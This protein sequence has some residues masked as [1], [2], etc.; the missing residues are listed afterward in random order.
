MKEPFLYYKIIYDGKVFLLKT[1]NNGLKFNKNINSILFFENGN[2]IKDDSKNRVL[3][4]KYMAGWI[5][6][7][8]YLSSEEV[9][10]LIE[11]NQFS[12]EITMAMR[13]TKLFLL[14]LASCTVLFVALLILGCL[15]W[16]EKKSIIATVCFI[17]AFFS[18]LGQITA[19]ALTLRERQRQ[20]RTAIKYKRMKS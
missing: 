10:N 3:M 14:I 2:W 13:R 11:E 7:D 4:N 1:P 18:V 20:H 5:D 15:Y 19:L 9:K 8:D 16:L 6:E 17:L 12:H